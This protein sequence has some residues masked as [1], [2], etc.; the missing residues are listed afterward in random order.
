MVEQHLQD[1]RGQR[2]VHGVRSGMC[3]VVARLQLYGG[4]LGA[5]GRCSGAWSWIELIYLG[6]IVRYA[7]VA[8][9]ASVLEA[10]SV[11]NDNL[12]LPLYMW[13]MLAFA[14]A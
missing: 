8:T 12:T 2:R 6:Q 1:H 11:Q 9:L 14:E 13:S 7:T 3:L 10:F 5:S 4:L